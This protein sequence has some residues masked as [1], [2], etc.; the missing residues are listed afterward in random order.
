MSTCGTRTGRPGDRPLRGDARLAVADQADVGRRP[1]HVEAHRLPHP[2][3]RHGGDPAGGARQEQ[4]HRVRRGLLEGAHPAARL[5]HVWLGQAALGRRLPQ[6]A[7][8]AAG[9]R[10]Q[11]GVGHR[12]R[13]PLVLPELGGDVDRRDDVDAGQHLPQAAG[14]LAL[15]P[16]V[17]V[18]VKQAH[19]D[20]LD[21]GAPQPP[22][23]PLDGRRVEPA[24][25]AVRPAPLV[26]LRRDLRERR[27]RRDVEPVEVRPGLAGER[28]EVGE[29]G[30]GDQRGARAAPLQQRVRGDRRPVP[31]PGD[32][33]GVEPRPGHGGRDAL[34]NPA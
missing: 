21:A 14:H 18:G 33:A 10:A 31:E 2:E 27:R 24:Q 34:D 20:R 6:A 4:P 3:R 13:R 28:Q 22:R 8:V 11:V 17:G 1:A 16:G 19:G 5:H 9:H 26:H 29:P 7:Q 12:G 23:R 25:H 15:V 32:V 30:R